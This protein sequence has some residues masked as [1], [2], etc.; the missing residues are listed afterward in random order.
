MG[1]EMNLP[2]GA[3]VADRELRAQLARNVS[4]GRFADFVQRNVFVI[5]ALAAGGILQSVFSRGAIIADAW[6]SLLGGRI[7]SRSGLPHHDTLTVLAQGREWVDQQWLGHLALYGLWAAGGWPLATLGTVAMYGAAFALAAGSARLLGGSE[8]SVSLL[9]LVCFVTGLPNTVFRAQ[10]AA[11]PLFALVLL[12]LLTDERRQSR[13]VFVVFPLLVLWANVHGSVVLGAAL[14]ALR[15]ATLAVSRI[16]ERAPIGTWLPRAGLL[17][18]GPWLCALAAP[19]ASALPG[20]YHR[21]LANPSF[22]RIVSEWAPSTIRSQPVFFALLL[23]GLWLTFGHGRAL[24]PFARLALVFSGIGGLLAIRNVVWFALVAAAVLPRALDNLWPPR[25]APRHQRINL[26]L[27]AAAVLAL[28]V[29]ATASAAHGRR[30]FERDFPP[31]AGKVVGAAA[32]ADPKLE[33]FA[34]ERYAD[35]LLFEHP[36]LEG[37]VAY[38]VRFELLTGRELRGLADFVSQ[39]GPSW[40]SAADGYGLLVLDA[41]QQKAI[42]SFY[43]R[44][45]HVQTLYRDGHIAVLKLP[46]AR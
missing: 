3:A 20:Y 15:G 31:Q 46:A 32:A 34:N 36:L 9:L 19:Y 14:V 35:W 13:R 26:A 28:G 27:A 38:D 23:L 24:G 40:R 2:T 33:V 16:K 7:V 29:V 1:A 17:L 41:V 21:T 39:R 22:N 42:V 5:L 25:A 4:M 43:V 6:Y 45:V 10:V 11:Y 37:R 30:W 8:R 44:R 12:L 18:V